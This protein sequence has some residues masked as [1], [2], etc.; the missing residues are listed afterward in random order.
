MSAFKKAQ[1]KKGQSGNPA[2][3]PPVDKLRNEIKRLTSQ[4]FAEMLERLQ[5][6]SE[7]ELMAYKQDKSAPFIWR[8][9]A[10]SLIKS[11]NLGDSDRVET[12]V[13][14]TIGK[15]PDKIHVKDES[16]PDVDYL[17]EKLLEGI[18]KK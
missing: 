5:T 13:N 10:K 16:K 18:K 17:A 1:F 9:Y 14:R 3:R 15:V 11:Y 8:I 7:D 12:I 2:G 6:M 4:S